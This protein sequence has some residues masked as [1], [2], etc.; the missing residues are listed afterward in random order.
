MIEEADVAT[1]VIAGERMVRVGGAPPGLGVA[2][3]LAGGLTGVLGVPEVGLSAGGSGVI[4]V[5]LCDAW[6]LAP[7]EAVT[8][9][10]FVPGLKETAA[11]VQ[12]E[13]F[14]ETDTCALPASP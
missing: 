14:W 12:L 13:E 4:T 7:S 1:M 3:G 10:T 11:M 6:S 2:G 8:V 9:I 5:T